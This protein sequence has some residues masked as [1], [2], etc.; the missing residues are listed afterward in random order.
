MDENG[1]TDEGPS[2]NDR[3]DRGEYYEDGSGDDDSDSGAEGSGVG[4]DGSSYD[5]AP[6]GSGSEGEKKYTLP[7]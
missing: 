7:G 3:R 6:G 5:Y 1:G 4:D 2:Q